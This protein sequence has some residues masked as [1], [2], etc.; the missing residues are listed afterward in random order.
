MARW[1]GAICLCLLWWLFS[2][3]SFARFC[4]RVWN[5]IGGEKE[6]RRRF[7]GVKQRRGEGEGSTPAG[8]RKN[9]DLRCEFGAVPLLFEPEGRWRQAKDGGAK[10]QQPK[11][12]GQ[13]EQAR[14]EW[15][16]IIRY[17]WCWRYGERGSCSD[18]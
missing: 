6:C 5:Q 12:Q 9:H 10:A 13:R 18:V 3:R 4:W 2:W 7:V 14:H 8:W 15:I 11:A 1:G 17:C 16:I